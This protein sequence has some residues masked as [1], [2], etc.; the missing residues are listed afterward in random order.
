M[1]IDPILALCTFHTGVRAALD[2]FDDVALLARLGVVDPVKAQALAAFFR[3]PMRRHDEVERQVLLPLLRAA[4]APDRVDR[5]VAACGREHEAM[6]RVLDAVLAHVDDLG[7]MRTDPSGAVLTDAAVRLR[8][9]VEPHLERE[10]QEIF[11]LARLLLDEAAL[12]S[13]AHAIM[14]GEPVPAGAAS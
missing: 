10:E 9:I 5:L 4:H 2:A 7:A 11:P 1:R 13:L 6:E 14:P 3:G 12:A 8:K